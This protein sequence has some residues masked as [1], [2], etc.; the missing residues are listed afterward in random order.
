MEERIGKRALV[1][2]AALFAAALIL[3]AIFS[4]DD[5]GDFQGSGSGHIILNEIL[6][7]NR[8]YPAPDGRYLDFIEVRNLS[9]TPTDISGYMLAD[10]AYS[11]G[12]TFPKGTVLPAYGY[13]VCWCDKDSEDGTYAAFG[14]SK[15]GG[16]TIYLYNS[17][18][19]LVDQ[20][21]VPHVNANVPLVRLEDGSWMTAQQATPGYENTQQGYD[22]W[23]Q[24][25]GGDT[26]QVVISEV[27]TGGSSV[28]PDGNSGVCDWV[29]LYNSGDTA[30]VLDGAYLSNDP[31][32]PAKWQIPSLRLAPGERAVI[33]CT[34][35]M[36]APGEAAFNL[37]RNGCTVILT[38]ALGNILSQVECPLLEKDRTWALQSDGTYQSAE[39]ATPGFA[40]TEEGY[41]AW[42]Q[43]IGGDTTRVVISEIMTSNRS[44]VTGAAG[45]LCDWVELYNAGNTTA[46]LDGAYL[47]NDPADRAKWQIPNLRLEPGERKLIF[48]AGDLAETGEADFSLSRSGC[49]VVLTG[50]AGNVLSQVECPQLDQ[51]RVWALQADG[52]Y[53][54]TDLATPCFENTEEGRLAF[55]SS[56]TPVGPLVI[57]EVMPSNCK[58]LRQSDGGYYDWIEL[59]NTSEN[60]IDL[61]NYALSK[62]PDEPN[63][64]P[65]P[66][67]I[68]EPGARIVIICSGDAALTG[69]YI[70][71]PFTL[72]REESW[73]YLS[74]SQGRFVDYIRIYDVPY[75]QSVGRE[76]NQSGTFYFTEPSPGAANGTG[77]AF[78][79]PSPSFLTAGGVFNDIQSLTVELAGEGEL[80]YTLDGSLPTQDSP[81]YTQPLS[82]TATAVVRAASFCEGKL[83]SD[84]ITSSYII[85]E[86]HTL[87]VLSLTAEPGA[88]FG[89]N[90]I[91]TNY[92]RDTEIPCNLTLFEDGT[93][94]SIDCGIKM[95]GHTGLMNPKKSF[96]VNF[97]GRYGN[98]LL[99]YPVYGEDG[100]EVYDSLCI[101]AGQ[102]YPSSIFRDE[103]FTSLCRQMSGNV[104]AQRD[105]FCILYINGEY[106]GIYCL[107]EAFTETFYAENKDVSPDSVTIAQAPVG[108]SSEIF[109][110]INY[111]YKYDLS[112]QENYDYVSS[113]IDIDSLIDWMIIE[114]YS[115]N[116]DVQQNLR[117]FKSTENGDKWQM[118]FYDLDW[119]FY[120]HYAFSHVLSSNQ[121]WQHLG[122]TRNLIKNPQFRQQ[123]L[124]RLSYHME[125]TLSNENVL[126]QIDF[127]EA[128][129]DPEV[130]RE[131][132][133]WGGSYL[134]WQLKVQELRDFITEYDH[135]GSFAGQLR[136]F[137]GLTEQ[138][139]ETYFARWGG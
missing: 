73:V 102:D 69:S 131:R 130:P 40:N 89:G 54:E 96:K 84:V 90:G 21:E 125:H 42:L 41:Q 6:A 33:R 4:R 117:Y 111:C 32:D 110:L 67:R 97:R 9:G 83:R 62:D 91:Y 93:G 135:L 108:T 49:T 35:D 116:G 122:L 22:A 74:D 88:L 46:V 126:A 68:L 14:I 19:V 128:L 137:I 124:K 98:A 56:Q 24:A 127:Y 45:I 11:I 20:K 18:N 71:A 39:T 121:T 7:S 37:S 75:Q 8:T 80:H 78:I 120:Y 107:K 123:F 15:D 101:R 58:Y 47:S 129:L 133:R 2:C 5:I 92:T 103:L 94:F 105:K 79:S 136:S 48:C 104:L 36:A 13:V 119:A 28:D 109:Q 29:E 99:N 82:L 51:D 30:A 118:A 31:A 66:Q 64:F 132:N 112:I 85:N 72:S 63:Q 113:R 34:G 81:L 52:T 38:G 114:G 10:N 86:N 16:D 139:A 138:E 3:S 70:Q 134:G 12:Y 26:T 43:A 55:L 23:L 17:A 61:S 59:K 53:L 76:E 27:M 25:M 100:P 95:H 115:T 60:T 87:P 1:I 77:T 65:L 57:S 50:A 44:T 106:F